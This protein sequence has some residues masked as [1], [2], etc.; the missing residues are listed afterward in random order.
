MFI[1]CSLLVQKLAV[2]IVFLISLFFMALSI[3][4]KVVERAINPSLAY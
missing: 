1:M 3:A 2:V 4:P